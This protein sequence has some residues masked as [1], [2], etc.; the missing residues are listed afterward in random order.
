MTT[1]ATLNAR[2][3]RP[4]STTDRPP[5]LLLHGLGLGAF[6]WER[7]QAQLAEQGWESWAVD[8]PGH[9]ATVGERVGLARW[10][11]AAEACARE[12]GRPALIGHSLSGLAALVVSTRMDLHA[13]ALIS[14]APCAPVPLLLPWRGALSSL[15]YAPAVLAGRPVPI[16][17]HEVKALGMERLPEPQRA[18]V[19]AQLSPF[20]APLLRELLLRRPR[21]DRG[22]LRCPVLV[23]HGLQ[24]PTLTLWGARL[25]ADHLHCVLWRFDDLAHNGPMEPGGERLNQAVIGWLAQPRGRKVVEVEAMGPE[26]GVGREERLE[27]R[28]SRV[29]SNSRFGAR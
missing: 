14:P 3:V 5:V 17:P 13:A 2:R 6:L 24:D 10:I 9:G 23:T 22:E 11:D 29:R 19:I 8:M 7:C 21:V 20:P 26:E 4:S 12:L 16:G 1:L 18:Q 15:R 27:R 28:G 25:L